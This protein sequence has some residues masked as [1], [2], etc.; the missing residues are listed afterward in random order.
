MMKKYKIKSPIIMGIV[1]FA[2]FA[3]IYLTSCTG[4]KI[5]EG[6]GINAVR[7]TDEFDDFR[8]TFAEFDLSSE[9]S[10]PIGVNILTENIAGN[11]D[12]LIAEILPSRTT[13]W[14]ARRPTMA[15]ANTLRVGGN[16]GDAS[17]TAKNRTVVYTFPEGKGI[18]VTPYTKLSYMFSPE[19]RHSEIANQDYDFSHHSAHFTIDLK[20]SDGTLLT[21]LDVRDQYGSRLRPDDFGENMTFLTWQWNYVEAAISAAA[22][23]TI[24]DI[25]IAYE[26]SNP[27]QGHKIGGWFDDVR[28]FRCPYNLD[29]SNVPLAYFVDIRQ[30]TSVGGNTNGVIT[31]S[32]AFPFS[33]QYWA[34]STQRRGGNRYLYADR[35]LQGFM[36]SHLASRH[37]GERVSYLIQANSVLTP[38]GTQEEINTQVTNAVTNSGARFSN[39]NEFAFHNFYYGVTYD[40]LE[41]NQEG[42]PIEVTNRAPGVTA[43]ITPTFHGAV[44]RFTFPKGAAARNILFDQPINVNNGKMDMTAG[45]QTFTAFS[46]GSDDDNA[47]TNGNNSLRRKHMY[48]EFSVAPTNVFVPDANRVLSMASF[49]EIGNGPNGETIILLRVTTSWISQHQA[50]RNFAMDMLDRR[51]NKIDARGWTRDWT[52]KQGKWFDEVKAEALKSWNETLAMVQITDPT[53]SWWQ[54]SDFYSKFARS[55]LYPTTLHEYTGLGAT[56]YQYPSP[57][58]GTTAEPVIMDGV[59][60]YNEGWWD[61]YK[62]KWPLLGFIQPDRVGEL[63]DGI[64]Q[65]AID[66]DGKGVSTN[67]EG[68][69]RNMAATPIINGNLVGHSVPRWINPGGNNMMTGTS[70]DAV[71]ADMYA[72]FGADLKHVMNGY[73]AW[74]KNAS[75]Y[76]VRPEYGGRTGNHE[77]N[78]RGFHPWGTSAPA[79]GGGQRDV[80][81]TLEGALNDAAQVHMLRKMA[82]EIENGNLSLDDLGG[83]HSL[84]Y[85]KNRFLEEAIY[86]ENRAKYYIN[87]FD[88]SQTGLTSNTRGGVI[89][90]TSGWM[91]QKNRDGT[92]RALDPLNWGGHTPEDNAWSNRFLVPQDGRGMAKLFGKAMIG[93]EVIEPST[94]NTTGAK[95]KVETPQQALGIALDEGFFSRDERYE[96][97]TGSGAY[98]YGGHI[99]EVGSK[100]EVKM[101]EFQGS[102]QVAYHMPWIYLH[103]DRPWMT[104]RW[105]R[106]ALQRIFAGGAIGYGYQGEEDNGA[107]SSWFVWASL[108]LYNLDLGSG[109]LVIG[110]PAFRNIKITD[111]RGRTIEINAPNNSHEN[112]YI[113]SIKINGENW[114][115]PYLSK[116][117][118]YGG[119][120]LVIDYVMGPTPNKNLFAEGPPSITT[121]D[122][123]KFLDNLTFPNMP[124]I[125][126]DNLETL[127]TELIEKAKNPTIAATNIDLTPPPTGDG[128][129]GNGAAISNCARSLF[130]MMNGNT[131]D[132]SSTGQARNSTSAHFSAKTANIVY[133]DPS[134]PML[135][136]YT[137]TSSNTPDNPATGRGDRY[138]TAWTVWA[139]NNGKDW[140]EIDKRNGEIFDWI[141]YV[142]PFA[143]PAENQNKY[144]FYRLEITESVGADLRIGQI[145]FLAER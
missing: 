27:T 54:L 48:G 13:H 30:G 10:V 86:Y 131:R 122:E 63:T 74:T 140:V 31:P 99:H 77:G 126:G 3:T 76:S 8:W 34:P 100:R 23:K 61:T 51:K 116:E 59:F 4:S 20:F 98:G 44:M 134:A 112:V 92:F 142:R 16:I 25:I 52:P 67:A 87:V 45:G 68:V 124:I 46:Q 79:G 123:I 78:F 127:I 58:R 101:G 11:G 118:I 107:K 121:G 66:Q 70:S 139:S 144:K 28:I 84:E 81:W 138:P 38:S 137:I 49:P 89:E 113:Q 41:F 93:L 40:Q 35:Q 55:M 102:N 43:E 108:G 111:D 50:Q 110:S 18:V 64:I 53:A 94:R 88:T 71:I 33:P 145:Q 109:T 105:T 65:H 36:T 97:K 1:G 75:V 72:S 29:Y 17:T 125:V 104:Q 117:M 60:I 136:M 39:A 106:A 128:A 135:E 56:G 130:D 5:D 91:K 95:V 26:M 37:M 42:A 119:I 32:V 115:K 24:T 103:S 143:I 73:M 129:D 82:D 80:T 12:G 83:T 7:P 85:W 90:F 19:S 47:S 14:S 6:F 141:G 69:T 15:G 114:T 57:Y 9:S 132:N 21:E 133:F 62:S 22:G 2:A 120:D 96:F